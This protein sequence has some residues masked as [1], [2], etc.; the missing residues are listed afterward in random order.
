MY[1]DFR[2][3]FFNDRNIKVFLEVTIRIPKAGRN[4]L[5]KVDIL[6][7]D[8]ES[9]KPAVII[10]LKYKSNLKESELNKDILKMK[11]IRSLIENSCLLYSVGF[12]SDQGKLFLHNVNDEVV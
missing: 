9:R 4:K 6:I 2:D 3:E 5:Y 12:N 11:E 10:E 1:V 7:L 8:K